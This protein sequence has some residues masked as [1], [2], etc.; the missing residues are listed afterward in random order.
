MASFQ[1]TARD[2][3]G[4]VVSDMVTAESERAVLDILDRRGL[5]PVL[6]EER[7]VGRGMDF[8][9]RAFAGR[10]RSDELVASEPF[11]GWTRPCSPPM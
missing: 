9:K 2:A 8:S 7:S 5:F 3:Q 11:G 1:F 6:I 10:V 4:A